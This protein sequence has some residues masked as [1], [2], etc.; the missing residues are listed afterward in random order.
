MPKRDCDN[1]SDIISILNGY[2]END[3]KFV[4]VDLTKPSQSKFTRIV[5]RIGKMQ[6]SA[7]SPVKQ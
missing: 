3:K 4:G 7:D 1:Y 6:R 2:D 5:Q